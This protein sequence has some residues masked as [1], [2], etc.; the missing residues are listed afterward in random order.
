VEEIDKANMAGFFDYLV[1][2]EPENDPYTAAVKLLRVNAFIR[3]ILNLDSGKGPIK[4]SDY[5][6]E[7]KSGQRRFRNLHS[8]RVEDALRTD[9]EARCYR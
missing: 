5:R 9:D 8:R 7:L 3:T 6:R 2:D 4:K 1:D